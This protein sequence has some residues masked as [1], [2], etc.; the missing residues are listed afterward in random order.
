M[1]QVSDLCTCERHDSHACTVS[2]PK[3]RRVAFLYQLAIICTYM[4]MCGMQGV[5]FL[6]RLA[7]GVCHDSRGIHVAKMAGVPPPPATC[8]CHRCPS[9]M[10][11]SLPA[12]I[13]P[14][15]AG[16]VAGLP[17][18]VLR[19]AAAASRTQLQ[20]QCLTTVAAALKA[21]SSL[22]PPGALA[23]SIAQELIHP[24]RRGVMLPSCVGCKLNGKLP[25]M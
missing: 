9:L 5:V 24:Y 12:A 3:T 23:Q 18:Q 11:V 17:S 10:W 14:L 25:R 1:L 16:W 15:T 6:Y 13:N 22:A 7:P 8:Q 4:C 21:V 2:A 20:Q 19:T